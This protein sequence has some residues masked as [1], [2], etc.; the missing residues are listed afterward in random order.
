MA[1]VLP[2][3][4]YAVGLSGLRAMASRHQLI[5]LVARLRS[6]PG[7]PLRGFASPL[8]VNPTVRIRLPVL[9]QLLVKRPVQLPRARVR[10]A[11]DAAQP[12]AA[13]ASEAQRHR[14]RRTALVGSRR[15]GGG[16]L[17]S[18]ALGLQRLQRLADLLG[19]RSQVWLLRPQLGEQ[20][21]EAEV[22][23]GH[24]QAT[25]GLKQGTGRAGFA[26]AT[27]ARARAAAGPS[28][29]L[30]AGPVV[31]VARPSLVKGGGHG[32][33]V[34]MSD[35]CLHRSD[36]WTVTRGKPLYISLPGASPPRRPSGEGWRLSLAP[37]RPPPLAH[38]RLASRLPGPSH[39]S[40]H[41]SQERRE[42]CRAGGGGPASEA[43]GGQRGVGGEER[44]EL[45][46]E[47][48]RVGHVQRLGLAGAPWRIAQAA[49]PP[50]TATPAR[51]RRAHPCCRTPRRPAALRCRRRG[52]RGR[53]QPPVG[54]A[55]RR[56]P[57][58]ARRIARCP[59]PCP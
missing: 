39:L 13:D 28:R 56:R 58:R 8:L 52:A 48:R 49:P 15:R 36:A 30:R 18:L 23:L 22:G 9:P 47:L 54:A 32:T 34:L 33:F 29:Q 11:V 3:L 7:L 25:H 16:G 53:S 1:S 10:R 20:R 45:R 55:S 35:T 38:R 19:G 37:A 44:G 4:K 24:S 26:H 51:H 41:V 5:V 40:R 27:C 43:L 59:P 14:Q 21:L 50:V 12:E 42:E 2:R 31:A 46:L 17:G 57:R 6:V